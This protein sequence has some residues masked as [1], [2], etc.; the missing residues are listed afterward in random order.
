MLGPM[1]GG[2]L[3]DA[4]DYRDTSDFLAI[5]CVLY[6]I[7]YFVFNVGFSIIKDDKK[8]KEEVEILRESVVLKRTTLSGMKNRTILSL[9]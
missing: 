2:A 8:I 6:S 3:Y 7:I 1:I 9:E 4:I 5:S